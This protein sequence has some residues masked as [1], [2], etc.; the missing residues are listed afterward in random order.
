MSLIENLP[1]ETM[2]K[3][4]AFLEPE[5]LFRC[6]QV[7][8]SFRRVA[9]DGTLWKKLK[10]RDCLNE[11]VRIPVE[12]IKQALSYGLKHLS[13]EYLYKFEYPDRNPGKFL[14]KNN[15]LTFPVSQ[16]KSLTFH[17]Q[18][19]AVVKLN[20][21]RV[22]VAA[23]LKSCHGLEKLLLPYMNL[24]FGF[25]DLKIFQ[26]IAQNGGSLKV[27]H[28]SCLPSW[29]HLEQAGL[30]LIVDNC[31]QLSELVMVSVGEQNITY[32]C[33]NLTPKIQK[34]AI[35][36][37]M[38]EIDA[39]ILTKRCNNLTSL[40]FAQISNQALTI[41]IKNLS[42]SLEKIGFM[43]SNESL[44]KF[45]EFQQMTKLTHLNLD[46]GISESD[47]PQKREMKNFFEK[48]FPKLKVTFTFHIMGAKIYGNRRSFIL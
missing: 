15:S 34:L 25:H 22:F 48:R 46:L 37:S 16:L 29:S 43:Y 38:S 45:L 5:D 23:L 2:L 12:L 7:S 24:G 18:H 9:E 35:G 14:G 17:S 19:Y 13:I 6:L 30:K 31:K 28:L 27:L 40:Y 44:E 10:I 26:S 1:Q 33:N 36:T 20:Q 3:I 42:Q 39:E 8:K 4:F 41:V 11:E 32:F 47:T 21:S